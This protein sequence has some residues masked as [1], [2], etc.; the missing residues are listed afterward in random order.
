MGKSLLIEEPSKKKYVNNIAGNITLS[1]SSENVRN[2]NDLYHEFPGINTD[3]LYSDPECVR[4][5]GSPCELMKLNKYLVKLG[6]LKAKGNKLVR[7]NRKFVIR[8]LPL[9]C[10]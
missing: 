1:I 4:A 7:L 10:V 6:L 3:K 2:L 8:E 5:F 9:Y